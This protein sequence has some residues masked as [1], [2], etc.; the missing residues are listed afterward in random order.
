[1]TSSAK[2]LKKYSWLSLLAAAGTTLRIAVESTGPEPR[3]HKWER[4]AFAGLQSAVAIFELD[5]LEFNGHALIGVLAVHQKQ[6]GLDS[7]CL[8]VG[9]W[10]GEQLQWRSTPVALGAWAA[11]T[12]WATNSS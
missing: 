10:N 12:P 1:M 6:S 7:Y 8:W 5:S 4:T 11:T 9:K 2:L 3:W